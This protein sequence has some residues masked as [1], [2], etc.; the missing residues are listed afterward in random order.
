MSFR[1]NHY[2]LARALRILVTLEPNQP[3][4]SLSQAAKLIIIDWIS[5]HSVNLSLITSQADIDAIKAIEKI[6]ADR[7]DPYTTI[8]TI[9]AQAEAQSQTVQT[10]QTIQARKQV[11]KTTEQIQR[12]LEE[13]RIFQEMRQES[14][15]K[16]KAQ[17]GQETQKEQETQNKDLDE[18]IKLASQTSK[19]LPKASEFHDPNKTESSISTV[20][21]F[22]PPKDWME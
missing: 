3:I 21:D 16:L 18:Q 7:I 8:Q 14:L 20:T 5:K 22:S 6:P 15:S 13:D 19:H 17:K 2:Q 11:Q 1:L 9:M 10:Q 12:E 4:P